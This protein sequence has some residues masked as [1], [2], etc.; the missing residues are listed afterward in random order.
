MKAPFLWAQLRTGPLPHSA[1]IEDSTVEFHTASGGEG[2]F[3]HP[4]PR[5]HSTGAP[6]APTATVTWKENALATTRFLPW[7]AELQA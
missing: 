7:M 1:T 2:S 3:C 5:W 6:F 4:S